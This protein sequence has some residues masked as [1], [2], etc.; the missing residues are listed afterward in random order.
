M[1]PV[2][3]WSVATRRYMEQVLKV[4]PQGDNL[5]L[6][7]GIQTIDELENETKWNSTSHE[8]QLD[9]FRVPGRSETPKLTRVDQM[10][11]NAGNSV[12]GYLPGVQRQTGAFRQGCLLGEDWEEFKDQ[13][14]RSAVR[15]THSSDQRPKYMRDP[16]YD[17]MMRGKTVK[18]VVN[19][20]NVENQIDF[21]LTKSLRGVVDVKNPFS[22]FG[23][24]WTFH[25]TV[26]DILHTSVGESVRPP[27]PT[28]ILKPMVEHPELTA[29]QKEALRK[30]GGEEKPKSGRSTTEMDANL[31]MSQ[32]L[33][34]DLFC[35]TLLNSGRRTAG[36]A[37]KK[38][39]T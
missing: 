22:R 11:Q 4:P 3:S 39:N 32:P 34:R 10:G 5:Q 18:A 28:G 14:V 24:Q 12:P 2:Q 23:G 20:Y 25:D 38:A 1:E 7:K 6:F 16:P 13:A 21:S 30:R 26:R 9:P 31:F 15:F 37:P 8:G 35:R 17:T 19:D 36:P 33:Q 27:Q 29:D